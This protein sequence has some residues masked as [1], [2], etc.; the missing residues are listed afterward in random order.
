MEA[1]LPTIAQTIVSLHSDDG[2]GAFIPKICQ[3]FQISQS[4][5]SGPD[6]ELFLILAASSDLGFHRHWG[7]SMM[8]VVDTNSFKLF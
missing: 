6:F 1:S 7:P 8:T 5:R 3:I 4:L 2:P